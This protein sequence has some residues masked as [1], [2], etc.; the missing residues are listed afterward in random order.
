MEEIQLAEDLT[1]RAALALDN[2]QTHELAVVLRRGAESANKAKTAFLGAMSHELRTPLNAIGGY[3]DLLDMG[4]RGPVT[5]EQHADFG[6]IRNSQRH[7]VVLIT[8]ILNYARAGAGSTVYSLGD[9]N[10]FDAMMRAVD[11]IEPLFAQRGINFDGVSGDTTVLMHAETERV[12]QI[13]VNLLSNAI[14]FTPASGHI[15][16]H[17]ASRGDVV[18]I[19][20]SD[21]GVGIPADK[22]E[23][24]FEPFVQIT[25]GLADR[26]GGV[27]LGLA[28][29][30]DLARAMG[31]DVTVES[32]EGKGSRF[33]LLLPTNAP[34]VLPE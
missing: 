31:G 24:I 22:L 11:L 6:R 18:A 8:E 23:S 2:A 4:L 5:E 34:A 7:L 26:A 19:S 29:S 1:R 12:A 10:A 21:T 30:R 9:M 17:C 15:G 32:T 20:V 25:D 13:L 28:I 3:V 33:T 14:K 16:A 27:G